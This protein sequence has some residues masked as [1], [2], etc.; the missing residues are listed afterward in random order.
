MLMTKPRFRIGSDGSNLRAVDLPAARASSQYM[1]GEASPFFFSWQPALRD[2][3]ES[4]RASYVKAAARA[5]DTIQNSGWIAGAFD[6]AIASTIGSDGLRLASKPDYEA[7][8]WTQDT[9]D[10]W[11]RLV[12]RRFETWSRE[13]LECDAAGKMTL[14]QMQRAVML[15]YFSHGEGLSLLPMVHRPWS[16]TQTKVKLM[17]AHKLVQDSDGVRMFQGVHMDA[18]NLPVAYRMWMRIEQ[19]YEELIDIAARDGV[20]RPQVVHVFQGEADQVRGISP[21][22]PVLRVVRQYDQLA[23]ATLTAALIQAI[24]AAT[25][26]SDA[27]TQD[28]LN[29]LQD[30]EEQ[31]VG[32]GS[33]D[34]LLAAKADWYQSTKID[35]GRAGRIAHLF[36]GETLEFH[37]SQSPNAHY[38]AFSKFL[39]REIARCLGMTFEAF[40]GDYSGATYSSVRM[41]TSEN[42]PVITSRRGAIPARFCQLVLEAWL[43]EEIET[44]R[45]PFPGGVRGYLANR[46]AAARADWRG[47]AKPQADD[48]KTQKAHE[49]YKR[50]GVMTDEQIC[51]ELGQDWE[52]VYEQRKREMDRR[53][54]LGLPE[55]DTLDTQQGEALTNSLIADNEKKAA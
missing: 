54:K 33:I 29:A 36:P 53:R 17:P 19:S 14:A 47:P 4:V 39:L 32:G 34:G 25:I 46:N 11:A 9:S 26:K 8:G 20:G 55:G 44:G 43:E 27:P 6:Q 48:L 40:T 52:D 12:E 2:T 22:A 23:D 1:R 21:L 10:K 35:L 50:M 31:G 16:Q 51:A 38:E 15:S 37:G 13:P 41:G 30:D 5:I 28:V 7:L 42:W 24:F 49:G 45:I 18:W 3:R